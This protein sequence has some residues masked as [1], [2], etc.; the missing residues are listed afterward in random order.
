MKDF[1]DNVLFRA[2]NVLPIYFK[3]LSD[4]FLHAIFEDRKNARTSN[5]LKRKGRK[6][7]KIMNTLIKQIFLKRPD[8]ESNWIYMVNN[9]I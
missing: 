5:G 1:V 6:N 2:T 9:L 8:L 4:I 7:K 3:T